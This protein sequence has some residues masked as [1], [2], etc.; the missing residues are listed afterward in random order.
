MF[1]WN[2]VDPQTANNIT[3]KWYRD[4][5][6]TESTISVNA[7]NKELDEIA[8][9]QLGSELHMYKIMDTNFISLFEERFDMERIEKLDIPND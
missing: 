3:M 6:E 9:S 7:K 1:R 5:F 8:Y 4:R 2:Q